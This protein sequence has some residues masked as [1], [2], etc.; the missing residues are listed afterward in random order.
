MLFLAGMAD[1]WTAEDLDHAAEA[2]GYGAA[3]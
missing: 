1:E 2:L 3:K